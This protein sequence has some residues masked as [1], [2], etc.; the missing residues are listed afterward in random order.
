MPVVYFLPLLRNLTGGVGKATVPGETVRQAIENLEK[1]YPG[2]QD[3]LCEGDRL[4]PNIAVV[5]DG[6]VSQ[7]RLRHPL[8][9]TSEVRFVPALSG[10][11]ATK[12]I[13]RRGGFF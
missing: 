4:R 2:I 1:H 7:L 13:V 6:A 12:E 3:C 11:A 8:A 9:E 10:G 5:V